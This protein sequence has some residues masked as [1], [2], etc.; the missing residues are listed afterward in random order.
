MVFQPFFLKKRICKAIVIACNTASAAAYE[1]LRDKHKGSIPIINVIDPI[2]EAIVEDDN[3]RH[4]GVIAT[5]TTIDSGVYQ[6]KLQRRKPGIELSV[7]PTPLL[8]HMIEEGFCNDKISN[9]V[10]HNYL[11]PTR[12]KRNRCLNFGV[13][14]LC[15]DSQA[16]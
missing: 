15:I 14:T 9:A 2:I 12:I 10:I 1:Y 7:L 6:E 8:A 5:K 3:I 4:V 11:Q 16:D 13:Y